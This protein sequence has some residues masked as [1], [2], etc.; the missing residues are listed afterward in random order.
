MVTYID[1]VAWVVHRFVQFNIVHN[2][3]LHILKL[4]HNM[5]S[6]RRYTNVCEY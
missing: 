6:Q 2:N 5:I 1:Y 4:K 3:D